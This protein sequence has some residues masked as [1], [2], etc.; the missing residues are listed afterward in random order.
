MQKIYVIGENTVEKKLVEEQL[1]KNKILISKRRYN[2]SS[3]TKIKMHFQEVIAK[4]ADQEFVKEYMADYSEIRLLDTTILIFSY[5]SLKSVVENLFK[6]NCTVQEI[7]R[8]VDRWI[9]VGNIFV[10]LA[11]FN[12]KNVLFLDLSQV[13]ENRVGFFEELES[14]L[15]LNFDNAFKLNYSEPDRQNNLSKKT[16]IKG[17]YSESELMAIQKYFYLNF[18]KIDLLLKEMKGFVEFDSQ[19]EEFEQFLSKTLFDL[20][21]N[22]KSHEGD[23]A[24]NQLLNTQIKLENTLAENKKLTTII[25]NQKNKNKAS[26]VG[27]RQKVLDSL[28]YRVGQYLLINSKDVYGLLKIVKGLGALK[29]SNF[30]RLNMEGLNNYKDVKEAEK[31]MRHLSFRLGKVV[32]NCESP[33][34]YVAIPWSMLSEYKA[35]KN[36]KK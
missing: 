34:D 29:E 19:S 24:L 3:K 14:T 6:K 36:N 9:F 11:K 33:L 1:R 17:E 32:L 22:T 30:S 8:K 20:V 27:A 25:E 15:K 16:K 35:F 23:I 12:P 21:V 10:R 2:T 28:E 5:Y 7:E 13:E 31:V 18:S 26:E 4:N